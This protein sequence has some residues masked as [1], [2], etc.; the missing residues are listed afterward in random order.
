M[1][2]HFGMGIHKLLDPGIDVEAYEQV[3]EAMVTGR[4]SGPPQNPAKRP[5]PNISFQQE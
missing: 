2:V 4:L 1:G 5:Q 3:I